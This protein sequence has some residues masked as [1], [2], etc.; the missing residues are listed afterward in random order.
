[1]IEVWNL[2]SQPVRLVLECWQ[3]ALKFRTS[4]LLEP[5]RTVQRIP[6]ASMNIDLYRKV[7]MVRVYPDNDSEAH[8]VFS[9]LDFVRYRQ[10][11]N[12]NAITDDGQVATQNTHVTSPV[13]CVIWDLD[14][15][16]WNGILGDQDADGLFCDR[17]C[18]KR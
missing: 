8:I 13:K 12:R 3:Q 4:I 1:M 6:A 14:Q 9:W 16:A 11:V 2:Q 17:T 10:P 18:C 7:G 5:G 15:T